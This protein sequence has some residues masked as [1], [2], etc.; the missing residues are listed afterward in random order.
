M[1]KWKYVVNTFFF[2][3]EDFYLLKLSVTLFFRNTF[4][5]PSISGSV[6][7]TLLVFINPDVNS[8]H[9]QFHK[10]LLILNIW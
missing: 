9:H 7:T 10:I 1:S 2:P 4:S 5:V 8:L 3:N 6:C